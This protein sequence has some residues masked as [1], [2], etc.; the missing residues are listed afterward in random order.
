MCLPIL[1]LK[2]HFHALVGALQQ[3]FEWADHHREALATMHNNG[4]PCHFI[5]GH[6]KLPMEIR[7]ANQAILCSTGSIAA[8]ADMAVRLV[9]HL[10]SGPATATCFRSTVPKLPGATRQKL[11]VSNFP[12]CETAAHMGE[13][14]KHDLGVQTDDEAHHCRQE[15]SDVSFPWIL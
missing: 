7:V 4:S 9:T 13:H 12:P 6:L 1:L 11:Q 15:S 10:A 5:I 14:L 2:L 3:I 8:L